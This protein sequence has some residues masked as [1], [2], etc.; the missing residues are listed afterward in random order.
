[1]VINNNHD[2]VCSRCHMHT[3]FFETFK[4][5]SY[6]LT[7][8]CNKCWS[9]LQLS[10]DYKL[11]NDILPKLNILTTKRICSECMKNLLKDTLESSKIKKDDDDYQ[12]Q[13]ALSLSKNEDNERLKQQ[14]R[15]LDEENITEKRFD[16]NQEN[17]LEKTTETIERFMNRANSNCKCNITMTIL[18]YCN[19]KFST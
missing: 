15:K 17:L 4:K 11:L 13:L 6:C 19:G 12:L 16:N 1:M 14:K 9:E 10:D 7:Q 8:H 18:N 5:C 2:N 3:K